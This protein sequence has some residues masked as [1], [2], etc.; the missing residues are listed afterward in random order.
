[1]HTGCCLNGAV[2]RKSSIRDFTFMQESLTLWKC[3]KTILIHS[4]SYFSLGGLRPQNPP[5]A[6]GLRLNR[7]DELRAR[8]RC[9][10]RSSKQFVCGSREQIKG[11]CR[12]AKTSSTTRG[13][14]CEKQHHC[15]FSAGTS[16]ITYGLCWLVDLGFLTLSNPTPCE[17]TIA[18]MTTVLRDLLTLASAL[19][20]AFH[21]LC[22]K[23]YNAI[24]VHLLALPACAS[25]FFT[26]TE[27]S[28]RACGS[29]AVFDQ[30][31]VFSSRGLYGTR[32]TRCELWRA[33]SVRVV[34]RQ[35]A[36][37]CERSFAK[38]EA[39]VDTRPPREPLSLQ[40]ALLDIER[41]SLVAQKWSAKTGW[42][43]LSQTV[44]TRSC[45]GG[46]NELVG[47]CTESPSLNLSHGN[48]YLDNHI[49]LRPTHPPTHTTGHF[50]SKGGNV[51]QAA[52]SSDR[53]CPNNR[54]P[55]VGTFKNRKL[56]CRVEEAGVSALPASTKSDRNEMPGLST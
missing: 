21:W 4:V 42:I 11:K 23:T 18:R 36:A 17:R 25:Y 38:L 45:L 44:N 35:H 46:Q 43:R 9:Q 55:H 29:S 22:R 53:R 16:A 37:S 24:V 20:N 6:T 32:P 33:N 26:N 49:T 40:E 8:I 54:L 28:F 15:N 27:A 50:G 13:L 14:R 10:A 31:I 2:A 48:L 3:D 56:A 51:H 30:G 41:A 7:I 34:T 12:E 19:V 47:K 5:E 52:H 39:S 1:M